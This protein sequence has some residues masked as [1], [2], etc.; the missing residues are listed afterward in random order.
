[1]IEFIIALSTYFTP[2][3]AVEA[4]AQF[5]SM[6]DSAKRK[7]RV[8]A[9]GFTDPQVTDA[10]IRAKKRGVDISVVM[11]ATQAAGPH[12]KPL[13]DQLLKARIPVAIGKSAK[14]NQLIHAKFVVVDDRYVEDG[15]WN[16]SP[17]AS[18]QD[19]FLNFDDDKQRA[20]EFSDFWQKV[21]DHVV[22]AQKKRTK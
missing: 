1:M 15:S 7:I 12:Q 5:I 21:Y 20:K 8:C 3:Q 18:D 4:E 22:A 17:S 16:Y 6:I 13:V 19:N 11:D 10:L 2:Y 9:Y 14:H